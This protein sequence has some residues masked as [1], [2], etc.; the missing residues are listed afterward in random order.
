M[1]ALVV[2]DNH[3][4]RQIFQLTLE[5]IGYSVVTKAD[6]LECLA[7]LRSDNFDIVI[8][9]LEMP[10]L[11]GVE[12]LKILRGSEQWKDLL[13]VVVTAYHHMVSETLEGM[14]DYILQKPID[15]A[16]FRVLVQRL[17]Q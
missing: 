7:A 10:Q 1:K 16:K 12:T 9:D 13:V 15:V 8:L 6:G 17:L 2:D 14:A 4:N 5:S 11:G 3:F